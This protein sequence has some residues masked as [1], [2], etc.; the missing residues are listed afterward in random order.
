MAHGRGRPKANVSLEQLEFLLSYGFTVGDMSLVL[1]C[2]VRTVHRRLTENGL[3]VRQSFT[4]IS[5]EDLDSI[6]LKINREYPRHGYRNVE[7]HLLERSIRVSRQRV[8]SS[9]CRVDPEGVALRWSYTVQRRKYSVYGPNALWHIDGQ[10]GLIRWRL[11]IHGGF[12]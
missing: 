11:V 12:Y 5:D 8:R 7:G 10:H 9:L 6:V 4:Q 3:S 1:G 2:S